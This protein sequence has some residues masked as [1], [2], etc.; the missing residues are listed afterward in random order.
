MAAQPPPPGGGAGAPFGLAPVTVY[1]R[2]F[3]NDNN[4]DPYGGTYR[5]LL[6]PYVTP[7]AGNPPQRPAEVADAIYSAVQGA[8]ASEGE[9]SAWF[10][11]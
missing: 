2:D 1:Y 10:F 11:A 8:S 3:Y 5:Q 4:N 7:I 6:N 9:G